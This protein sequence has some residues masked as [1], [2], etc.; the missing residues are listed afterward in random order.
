MLRW[1]GPASIMGFHSIPQK[2]MDF[3]AIEIFYVLFLPSQIF[4]LSRG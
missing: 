2:K 4:D 1:K 3:M